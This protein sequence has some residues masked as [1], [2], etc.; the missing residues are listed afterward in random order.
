[1]ALK[2]TMQGSIRVDLSRTDDR[3]ELAVSDTGIG[4]PAGEASRVFE[5]FHRVE[6]AHGRTQEGTGIGLSLVSELVKLH[7]GDVTVESVQGEGSTFRVSIPLGSEHLPADRIEQM[8]QQE[9]SRIGVAAYI[10]EALRWLPADLQRIDH[11][12]AATELL[13][14]AQSPTVLIADDNAD[15]RSYLR[16]LLSP[17]YRII[18]VGDGERALKE[19]RE[20]LPDLVLSDVMMPG[21]DGFGLLQKLRTNPATSS[22]PVVLLSARAG[23]EARAEGLEAGADDYIVKPFHA[24]ELLARVSA[25][26]ELARVRRGAEVR[27]TNLLEGSTSGFLMIDAEGRYQYVNPAAEQL[28]GRSS[29]EMIGRKPDEVFPESQGD[30]SLDLLYEVLETRESKETEVFFEPWDRW[31]KTKIDPSLDDGVT[32]Q[33]DEVTQMRKAIDAMHEVDRR[34]D[35]FLATLAHE[36]RNPLAPIRNGLQLLLKSPDEKDPRQLYEMMDR[37]AEH[38]TRLVNDLM[39][40]SRINRGKVELRLEPISLSDALQSSIESIGPEL[41]QR[42]QLLDVTLAREPVY[43]DGDMVRLAQVFSNLL[44][45]ASK[46]SPSGGRIGVRV[47]AASDEVQIDIIDEGIGLT[48]DQI[49]SI[50]DPFQQVE[51]APS[52]RSGGLGLGLGLTVVRELIFRHGGEVRAHSDG[53]G[54]GSCFTVILPLTEA[55]LQ[56]QARAETAAPERSDKKRVLI[57]DDNRDAADS[58]A[59]LLG[60]SGIE[61][62]VAYDGNSAVDAFAAYRPG[63][64]ILDIGLPDID[65]YEVARRIRQSETSTA[66]LLIALTGWGQDGDRAESAAAGF[67]RHF[68]KPADWRELLELI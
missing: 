5:R 35:E 47:T 40:V 37:Q 15:M 27:V 50:F 16:R 7:G 62:K 33:F 67:D 55:P 63:A 25:Q 12:E 22:V 20:Q 43:V 60:R 64:V 24:R 42:Q 44:G 39:E 65:G 19:T 32:V 45:N 2:Y 1:N 49:K 21:L 10:E 57:V 13:A 17:H 26:I 66:C 58:L 31:F 9:S 29:E 23:E 18:V 41:Q 6:G 61:V 68:V 34:K 59:E 30:T 56:V 48:T 36:L 53:P 8:P 46:F 11:D 28:L 38:L 52:Q 54:K 3:V 14:S 51:T 4:I